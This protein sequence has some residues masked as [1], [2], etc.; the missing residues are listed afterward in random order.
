MGGNDNYKDCASGQV[1]S[2]KFVGE[3]VV[4]LIW[5]WAGIATASTLYIFFGAAG[6]IRR[7]PSVCYP[8][9]HEVAEELHK[10]RNLDHYQTLIESKRI[11]NVDAD[12]IKHPNVV[13]GASYCVR[14]LVWRPPRSHHCSTC[15]R[16]FTGFDHHCGVFGRCIVA[17]NMPCFMA[18]FCMFFAGI[19][20]TGAALVVNCGTTGPLMTPE[21]PQT[22]NT[23]LNSTLMTGTTA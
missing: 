4:F 15:G 21:M 14:C 2:V 11:Q 17:N 23:T 10:D 5:L 16:C 20:T 12:I 3:M 8:I 18:N 19:I 6:V 9:P 22:V 7:S 1:G 13:T